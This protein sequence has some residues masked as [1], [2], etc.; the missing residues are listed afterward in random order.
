MRLSLEVL[1][2]RKGD[3]LLLHY[4]TKDAP[5]LILIDGGPSDVYQPHLKPRLATLAEALATDEDASLPID[6]LIVSHVD[7]D[8]IKGILELTS[9][10]RDDAVERRP[11]TVRVRT[12]W[13]NSFDD[14]LKTTPKELSAL[15]SF[16]SAMLT[17]PPDDSDGEFI[18][19]ASIFASIP[20][21]RQ[22]RDDA[23]LLKWKVNREFGGK[24]ILASEGGKSLSLEGGVEIKVVGPSKAQLEALQSAHDEWLRA[25]K[26]K[27]KKAGEAALAAFVD[28]SIPN[29]SSIALLVRAARKTML[30][31]GDARGDK[32]LAGLKLA[33]LMRS[34]SLHVDVLKVPHHGSANNVSREFFER[35]TADHYVFSGNGEHGNPERATIEMLLDARG[36]EPFEMHFTYPIE[37]IDVERRKDWTKEF[38]RGRKP[39]AWSAKKDSLAALFRDRALPAGQRLRIV[40]EERP[41]VIDLLE[42]VD[43]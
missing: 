24:L 35:V 33:G 15:A 6:A 38:A 16:G 11:Q 37:E 42:P 12:L 25:Q 31:T 7:D 20:Q 22:L 4:G 30:L 8:H 41:H 3:C 13:H 32:L 19:V 10:L 34:G 39:R 2:A 27:K 28:R 23:A 5:H 36:D 40:D 29:L 18:D 9:E 14:L 21:G 17:E 1:R 26:A 43:F